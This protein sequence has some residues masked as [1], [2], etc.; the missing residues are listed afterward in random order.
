[1]K[2]QLC[3]KN[4]ATIHL[5]EI[6]NEKMVELHIC[7]A[8]AKEKSVDMT[9][10]IS[11]NDILSGLVDFTEHQESDS[12][13]L[14]CSNCNMDYRMFKEAGR[15]GCAQCYDSFKSVL[16]PLIKRVHG[17]L[18]HSGKRPEHLS[19]TSTIEQEIKILSDKLKEHVAREEFEEAAQLRDQIKAL[20]EKLKE[21][22]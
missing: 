10:Q 13:L 19:K 12:S 1:M 9:P 7:E 4:D 14:R 15:L 5:T 3:N 6:V 8:C 11:F 22:K 21:D 18:Q 2:C 17:A 20:E 16:G